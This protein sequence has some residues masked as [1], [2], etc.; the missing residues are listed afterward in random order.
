MNLAWVDR[1]YL[2]VAT[3]KNPQGEVRGQIR[4]V[5]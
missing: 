3:V 2:N 5:G 4:V 1:L